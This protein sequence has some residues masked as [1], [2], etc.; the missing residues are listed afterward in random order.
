MIKNIC[1]LADDFY[2]TIYKTA[3]KPS[4]GFLFFC[5][6]DQTIFL[7][8]RASHMSSPNTWDVPGGQ[9]ENEDKSPL[10]TAIREVYEEIGVIPKYRTFL[11]TYTIKNDQHHYIVY[12]MPMSSE[13]KTNFNKQ[14]NLGEEND[15]ADWFNYDSI[16]NDT[17]FDLSWIRSEIS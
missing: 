11:Q 3:K 2:H 17:H 9:P 14:I 5:P 8:H 15:K 1:R 7:T 4:A 10:M 12:L 13:E 16:P 6:N